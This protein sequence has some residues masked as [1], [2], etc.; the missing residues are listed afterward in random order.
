MTL[1]LL[2]PIGAPELLII[3][4]LGLLMFGGRLPDVA[5]SLG[6]SVNQFKRGLKDVDDEVDAADRRVQSAKATTPR[7]GIAA[8]AATIAAMAPTGTAPAEAA[9]PAATVETP[10]SS[11][12]QS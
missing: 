2:G 7:E 10:P 4:M 8:P 12:A 1:A 5:R 6:K 3:L 9:A 11:T